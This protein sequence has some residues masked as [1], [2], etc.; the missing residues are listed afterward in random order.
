M[1]SY[2]RDVFAYDL[3]TDTS[4]RV[5]L[6]LLEP[7][8]VGETGLA[9]EAILGFV[10]PATDLDRLGP[11]GITENRDFL[12]LLSR[13]IW[14]EVDRDP[15]LHME[16]DAQGEGYVYL[17]DARTPD[18]GGRVPPEDIIGA[19]T[20]AAGRVVAG[21]FTHNPRQRLLTAHG[22][23]RLSPQLE[24]VLDERLHSLANYVLW[25]VHGRQL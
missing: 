2:G 20:V 10:G 4:D 12:R 25:P 7:A 9:A 19:V 14:E 24:V 21:S 22:C 11:E 16:A 1:I 13:V 23:F 15:T 6:S 3:G 18:P 17:L 5:A 8:W